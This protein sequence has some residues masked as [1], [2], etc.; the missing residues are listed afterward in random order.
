MTRTFVH[1]PGN[2]N[3]GV[4]I[5]KSAKIFSKNLQ[6]FDNFCISALPLHKKKKKSTK[7]SDELHRQQGTTYFR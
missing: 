3:E 5:K 7:F 4:V 6:Y 2:Q 1:H